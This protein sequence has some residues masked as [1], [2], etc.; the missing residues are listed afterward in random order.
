MEDPSIA[1]ILN[2][3]KRD[4]FDLQVD[5]ILNQTIKPQRILLWKNENHVDV[6]RLRDK[7]VEIIE[8]DYNFTFFGRF[9]L[10]CLLD[11]SII[12]LLDDDQIPGKKALENALGCHLRNNAMVCQN[13]RNPVIKNGRCSGYTGGGDGGGLEQECEAFLG[14]H[15]FLI[16]QEWAYKL[17]EFPRYQVA[18]AEDIAMAVVLREKYGIRTFCAK[19]PAADPDVHLNTNFN[20]GCD[21]VASFRRKEHNQQRI[22]ACNYWIDFFDIKF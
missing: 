21:S 2:A 8:S 3:Y 13:F 12:W 15:S 1:V 18:N 10:A 20:L 7:G 11:E 9:A 5:A 19:S 14:G 17:F 6:S 22:D 4:Y 16:K